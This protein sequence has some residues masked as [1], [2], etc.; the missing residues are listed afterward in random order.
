MLALL[1]VAVKISIILLSLY[2]FICSLSFL[3]SGFR[4]VAGRQAGQIFRNSE[5]FN[6]P[7]AGML[8]GVLVTV[9]VQSSS[10]STSIVITM[11]AADLLT[12]RQAI[13]LIMGANIGTSVT[14]T[15]V[16]LAQSSD[17]AEFRRAFAAATVHDMFNFLSVL[18]LL[19]VEA[20]TGF[21]YHV[22]KAIIDASPGLSSAEKPPDI[23][24][25]IT[26]PFTKLIMSVDKKVITKIATAETQ[27]DL[28]DLADARILK[29]FFG[30]G[31]DDMSDGASGAIVLI[32]ALAILC[33]TLFLIVYTLKSLLKGRVAVWLHQS[34]NGNVPD[35]KWAA[36]PSRSAGSRATLRWAPACSS[37]SASSLPRSRRPR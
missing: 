22:S 30:W 26:K 1:G 28:D 33:T 10:T 21:L 24:K 27:E 4:L 16:A 2:A 9:L 5:V 36:L 12:A 15:I 13:A 35:L 17:P 6:N 31:P 7:I 14:S 34:V 19:P 23:L 8:I 3:A 37:R 11:V 32:F 18:I 25:V 29:H 20:A